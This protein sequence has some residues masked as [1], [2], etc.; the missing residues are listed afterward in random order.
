[1][2][3]GLEATN[4]LQGAPNDSRMEPIE[5]TLQDLSVDAKIIRIRM[6]S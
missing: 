6:Q 3:P 2:Q 4:F 5:S 1:M